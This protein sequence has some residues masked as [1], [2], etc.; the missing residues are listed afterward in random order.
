MLPGVQK[1]VR[2]W[3]LTLP[4]EL[5]LWELESW[6]TPKFSERD[7][8]GQN[9][10]DWGVLY[11]IGN[12]LELK[13]LKWAHMTHLD[14]W[15]TSYAQKKGWE[16]NWQF[17][18]RPLKLKN[19][20]DFLAFR[21]PA[22][23]RWKDLEKNYNFASNLISIGGLQRKLWAFKVAWVLGLGISG[24]PLGSPGTKNH[25]DVALVERHK[26]YYKGEVVVS[27]SP[28]HGEP[29]ESELPVARLNT[30]SAPTMH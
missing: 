12:F 28:G 19:H 3:T 6:R 4:K 27:P 20:P 30:K 17:D 7:Y 26:I 21:W 11:I 1:S 10:L 15:N 2:E 22:R 14:I 9:S 16:S 25:L 5:P 24:L 13:C 23:Y 8:R 18:Y 29:C